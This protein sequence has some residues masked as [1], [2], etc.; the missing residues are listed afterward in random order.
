MKLSAKAQAALD[1]VVEKFQTGDLSDI[2]YI[3][4]LKREGEPVPFD[5]WTFSNQVLAY[6]QTGSTDCR[7]YRQWQATDRQVQKGSHAAFIWAPRVIK[8]KDT[9]EK[10]LAGFLSVPVFPY[11]ATDGEPLPEHDYQPAQLPPL[12][13]VAQRW[14]ISVS[15][16]PRPDA[17]GSCANDGSQIQLAT[18]DEKVF[19]HEL[20]H[21]AH[22]RIA[23]RLNGQRRSATYHRQEVV[24][25]FS[26]AVLMQMYGLRDSSGYSWDYI[27][28][29]S[30]D[31][32]VA[33][34]RA[35]STVAQV[36]ALILDEP[37]A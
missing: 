5:A 25:E 10:H 33:I 23:G 18:H 11:H 27:S 21:A 6:V 9:D 19:F 28:G 4:T 36:L 7:G 22:A 16:G 26:A 1:T 14:G 30:K 31:P 12:A 32:L 29:Y 34:Q 20:A 13:E 35:L 3:A 24:A 8:D 2:V 15:Y 17:R 37:T